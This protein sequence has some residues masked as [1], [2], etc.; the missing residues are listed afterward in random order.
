MASPDSSG[1]VIPLLT[2]R[3]NLFVSLFSIVDSLNNSSVRHLTLY[4]YFLKCKLIKGNI[5]NPFGL[6]PA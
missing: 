2:G 4:W 1:L 3:F 6:F 5:L